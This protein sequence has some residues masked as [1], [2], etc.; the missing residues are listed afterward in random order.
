MFLTEL[1]QKIPKIKMS[2]NSSK[3]A[4]IFQTLNRKE[5]NSKY[6]KKDHLSFFI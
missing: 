6:N 1:L 3:M 4:E 5:E 2:I